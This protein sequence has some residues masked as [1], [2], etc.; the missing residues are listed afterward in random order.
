MEIHIRGNE[1]GFEF[2]LVIT[3]PQSFAFTRIVRM[4]KRWRHQHERT[5][6]LHAGAYQV[7]DDFDDP[8]P[9]DF[10]ITGI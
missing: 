5:P 4:L 1:Q 7:R 3:Y 2:R 6:G 9:E 10:L 8:L